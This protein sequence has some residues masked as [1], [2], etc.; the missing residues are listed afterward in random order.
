[1]TE[2]DVVPPVKRDGFAVPSL[3]AGLLGFFG[4][5][6]VLGLVFGIV[7]LVRTRRT[8]ERGRGLAIGGIVAG[9]VWLV[10]LPVAAVL[11][12][13]SLLTS[14]NAP[15][16]AL[17]VENCYDTARP[18]R[19]ATRVPCAGEHDGVVLDAFTMPGTAYPGDREAKTEVQRGCEDRMANM[20]GGLG[21]E[22]PPSL[23]VVGYAP[24]EGAWAAGTRIGVCGLQL[25]AG[26]LVGP[27][28]R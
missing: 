27:L 18:G 16:A 8:G 25:G 13:G 3:V 4:L 9:A 28:P 6:A 26:K 11:V 21:A 14:S 10:A 15:I 7:T 12:L 5:T 23:V 20:F 24:D 22:V 17:E 2:P 19:D 1:M